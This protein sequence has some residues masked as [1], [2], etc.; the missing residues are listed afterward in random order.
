MAS[1]SSRVSP[2]RSL[3][4]SVLRSRPVR[5]QPTQSPLLTVLALRHSTPAQAAF[6]GHTEVAKLF[7][8]QGAD[9]VATNANKLTPLHYAASNGARPVP[10]P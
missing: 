1:P 10:C 7:L 8:D 6:N 2:N 4:S 9:V 5:C 3:R